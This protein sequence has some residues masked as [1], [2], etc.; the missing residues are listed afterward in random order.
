[1]FGG[2]SFGFMVVKENLVRQFPGRVVG[3][4]TDVDGK[5]AFVLTLQA[6]EQHIRRSKAKSNICSNHQLTALMAA[7]NLA[8]LGPQGLRELAAGSVRQ[9]HRLA[10][11]LAAAGLAPRTAIG[12]ASWRD[13]V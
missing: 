6:R 4:T 11:A 10:D 7:I 3:Q 9:A 13:S 2:P 1:N 8:A 5:R 12:R